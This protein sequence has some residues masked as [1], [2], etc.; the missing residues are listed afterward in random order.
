MSYNKL[1]DIRHDL[2]NGKITCTSLVK[3]YLSRIEQF[4]HLN[5]FI[6]VFNEEAL[7][8]A[9]KADQEISSNILKPLT[10]AVIGI[11]DV[12]C[13]K[14]QKV[15]A[16]SK[17]LQGFEALYTATAVQRLID[18]GAIIIGRLNCDE[19]AMGSSNENSCYGNVLNAID[20]TRVP[21]GSSGGSAV[22]VQAN[23]CLAALGTDTGGSIR[24]PASLTG[25]VGFKPT[26]GRISRYGLLAYASSFDQIGTFT[27]SVEDAALL[28][29]IMAGRDEYDSTTSS[30]A[31]GDLIGNLSTE[32][33]YKIAYYRECLEADSLDKD[34]KDSINGFIKQLNEAGHT[35]EAVP[36]PYLNYLV[37]A[38]YILT[39]AES[40]SNLARYDG[41]HYGFRSPNAESMD[42]VYIKSRS[43]GFGW[44]VKRRIMLGTFVLSAGYY[45]AY[46]SKAQ[47]VRKLIFDHTRNILKSYDFILSP[48]TPS[49]AFKIGE[50]T[51][52]PL[53]MY[54]SDIFTV[55]ANLVGLPAVSLPTAK[56]DENL[57]F[58]VQLMAD[59]FEEGKLLAFSHHLFE[60]K[61][62]LANV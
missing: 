50:K 2:I 11:K 39:T 47:K 54:L 51:E 35:I 17:I 61:N 55:Q 32:K 4:K 58:G 15:T 40:S 49:P 13:L 19:F 36:F 25:V 60:N 1:T 28:I 34:I 31:V 57:P 8:T 3:S 20:N 48:T 41:V 42:E 9:Q 56:N 18:A 44:E 53:Q 12:L 38:Y 62:E 26:Y 27:R 23:L 37:P 43:E 6:E 29:Q 14:G 5:A 45:D 21:G 10:G 30:I 16:S 46:Y 22:A 7:I 52:D 33:K 24:Q 59:R